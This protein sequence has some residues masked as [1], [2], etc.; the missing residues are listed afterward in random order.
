MCNCKHLNT[1]IRLFRA[2][3]NTVSKTRQIIPKALLLSNK[4]QADE[5]AQLSN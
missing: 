2:I 4:Q 1:K 3:L 5:K